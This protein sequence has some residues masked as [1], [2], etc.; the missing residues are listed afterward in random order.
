[1]RVN[2]YKDYQQIFEALEYLNQLGIVHRDIKLENI[3]FENSEDLNTL[4][5]IDLGLAI[6]AS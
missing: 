4:R 3:L 2:S 1:M 6:Y 5:I